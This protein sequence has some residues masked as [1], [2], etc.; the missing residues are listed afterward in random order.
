MQL[1][2]ILLTFLISLYII[3]QPGIKESETLTGINMAIAAICSVALFSHP[4]RSYSL[5][6]IFHLYFLFFFCIA[7]SIQYKNGVQL[8]MTVFYEPDYILTSIY[9][10]C[11]LLLFNFVYI[12]QYKST[13]IK[14]NQI[15][16]NET[17][18]HT[19][20]S[21]TELKLIL[22]SF[23]IFLLVFY[24]NNFSIL[25]MFFRGGEYVERISL[26]RSLGLVI[27]EFLRPMVMVLFL[28]TS[29]LRL[30][31][32]STKWILFI[33]FVLTDFPTSMARFSAAAMYIPVVLWYVPFLRKKNVFIIVMVVGLLVI[34]PFLNNFRYFDSAKDLS[35]GFDFSQF[36]QLHFDSYSEFM[37][38]LTE[39]IVTNGR[40]L[41]GVLF[42]WIPR[43]IWPNKPIGSGAYVA[44][45]QELYFENISMPFIGEGYI[46][47]GIVG[48]VFFVVIV[49]FVTKKLDNW[50]WTKIVRQVRDI[51]HIG[52]LL[53]IGLFL[54]IMRGDLLSSFAYSCGFLSSFF[55]VKNYVLKSTKKMNQSIAY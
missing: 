52:Y 41:L 2:Y 3:C 31:R 8:L 17:T 34:F 38:V 53:L 46:N 23:S 20:D 47:F 36:S 13:S 51:N 6:K 11:S 7:P 48:V 28:S 4:R 9:V 54:F 21:G 33:L 40:Q 14:H 25:S 55:F 29:V 30:R 35:I 12:L 43:S 50:Y 39:D 16:G 18:R 37:R 44:H 15:D 1:I 26:G 32:K 42:F 19:I 5:Y 45:E 10:L 22:L 27:T 49:A 24:R